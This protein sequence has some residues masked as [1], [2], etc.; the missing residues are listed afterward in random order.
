METQK[1]LLK[2]EDG[3]EVDV[4]MYR[5]LTLEKTK[6]TQALEIDSLKRRVK[7]LE[8]KKRSRTHKLKRLYKVGLTARVDSSK[9]EPSL[10][11]D[12]S[13]QGR[14]IDDIDVDEDI[15]IVN[16]QDDAEM[17]DVT[18]LHGEEVFVD[19]DDADKEVNVAGELNVA[20]ITTNL[21]ATAT[22]TTEEVTLAKAH[23][24]LKASKPKDKGKGIMVEEPMKPKKNDQVR[25]DEEVTLKLQA[26]F[27]EE[28]QRLAREKL[29]EGSSK[30][31]GEEI[32]QERSKKQKV[33]DDKEITKL[34]KLMEIIP[35]KEEVAN[36]VTPLAVK[37]LKI[38]DWKI[39]KEGKENY[40]QKEL[41]EI[42]RC[43]WDFP[44]SR[45]QEVHLEPNALV[46]IPFEI[47]G[48]FH[49][50]TNEQMHAHMKLEEQKEK[51]TKEAKL[52][53]LTKSE[54]IKVVI[55][56]ATK[57]GVDSKALQ[58]SKGGQE[59][60]QKQ[61]ARL[62]VLKRQRLEKLTKVKELRKKGLISIDGLLVAN[63]SL[64]RS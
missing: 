4:Y 13:K 51:V 56:V 30:R 3:K 10:G 19:N 35:N 58:S 37:S 23:A 6:T 45:P 47:N 55:E 54:I 40:Y 59:F 22:I 43:T 61:D 8:K 11:E 24:E 52:L 1:P 33:D 64:R 32:E 27:D 44:P 53:A 46:L 62:N 12:A 17:F 60:I 38:V 7:K 18:D 50:V 20:S 5:V 39:H 15:T 9:D 2:D 21:S 49:C 25:L 48:K 57:V 63:L 16:A 34:K 42:I 26:K 28:E 31:A 14:K 36:D 29:V 41:M